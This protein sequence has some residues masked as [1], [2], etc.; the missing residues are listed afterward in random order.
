[1]YGKEP[2]APM[3]EYEGYEREM[4]AFR[5]KGL[6]FD[7][8]MVNDDPTL[9]AGARLENESDAD[10]TSDAAASANADHLGNIEKKWDEEDDA[11]DEDDDATRGIDED[12]TDDDPFD[13][14]G[15][16]DVAASFRRGDGVGRGF[17]EFRRDRPASSAGLVLGGHA[18][19]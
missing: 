4:A 16:G 6:A 13:D 19:R 9:G 5:A 11:E 15:G 2:G 17:G 3:R 8:A 10:E 14:W 7:D 12:T 18:H 1:V